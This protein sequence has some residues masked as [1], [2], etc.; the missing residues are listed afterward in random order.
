ML[1]MVVATHGPETC[2]GAHPEMREKAMGAMKRMEEVSASL[3]ISLQGGWTN[4]P[5]HTIYML[6]D[7]PDAHVVSQCLME[8]GIFDWNV[9]VVNPVV[10]LQESMAMAEAR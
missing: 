10:T 9:A 7:A 3:G 6:V 2:P 5:A 1:H 4:M 8:L